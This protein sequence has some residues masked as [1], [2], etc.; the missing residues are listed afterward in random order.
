MAVYAVGACAGAFLAFWS[1]DC[2]AADLPPA[3]PDAA[4][5]VAAASAPAPAP[6]SA[7]NNVFVFGGVLTNGTMGQSLDPF[8]VSYEHNY[9]LGG[10]YDRQFY[11]FKS[12]FI[13]NGQV[14]VADR[15][16]DGNSGELWGG[17]HVQ[18]RIPVFG[19]AYVTPG[20]T[21]G[22][23]AVTNAIGIEIQ[24]QEE[25]HGN[26]HLLFM[27]SPELAL[28]L[29]SY[30]DWDL[31]YQLHHRSGLFGTLGHMEEGTNAEVVGLRYHF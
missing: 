31:V 7:L 21:V 13:V 25:N 3:T 1:A 20:L 26:A 2:G 6:Q 22:L 11:D 28:T 29:P 9:I 18:A 5:P 15:F 19:G 8:T 12:I 27:F 10:S 14:G 30:P 24:R 16:G 17:A 4:P 23:S